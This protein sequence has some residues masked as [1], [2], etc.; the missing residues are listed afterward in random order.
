MDATNEQAKTWAVDNNTVLDDKGR[1]ADLGT[2][3][4]MAAFEN[5]GHKMPSLKI[6]AENS[7]YLTQVKRQEE[8]FL[9]GLTTDEKFNMDI[10]E[11]L[12][13]K[14]NGDPRNTHAFIE[15]SDGQGR[16]Y[17]VLHPIQGTFSDGHPM[18]VFCKDGFFEIGFD[19]DH[20]TL[21]EENVQKNIYW[22]SV[23]DQIEAKMNELKAHLNGEIVLN[24]GDEGN[25]RDFR[26]RIDWFDIK[27]LSAQQEFGEQIKLSESRG[28]EL[29]KNRKRAE[30]DP[31]TVLKGI[32]GE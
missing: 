20:A 22:D 26:S 27:S 2:A 12:T 29:E 17:M 30:S 21:A 16:K 31:R 24:I 9:H 23:G 13:K 25:K 7:A 8:A 3:Q 1:V 28:I 15:V 10:L 18:I 32:F 5:V 11:S 19:K 14:E 6:P 4:E